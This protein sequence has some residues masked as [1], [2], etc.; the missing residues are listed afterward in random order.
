MVFWLKLLL[1]IWKIKFRLKVILI[2]H[3]FGC[4][5]IEI[6]VST[7]IFIIAVIL[8]IWSLIVIRIISLQILWLVFLWLV[9]F[10]CISSSITIS[11]IFLL[12]LILF[13]EIVHNIIFI[14]ITFFKN[15]LNHALSVSVLHWLFCCVVFYIPIWIIWTSITVVS[16]VLISSAR[17]STW[18]I[19]LA[20]YLMLFFKWN[21]VCIPSSV[22]RLSKCKWLWTSTPLFIW[23]GIVIISWVIWIFFLSFFLLSTQIRLETSVGLSFGFLS[24]F[25]KSV[26]S[27]TFILK[28]KWFTL[29]HGLIIILQSFCLISHYV[30]SKSL[31]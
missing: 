10:S 8:Q 23:L 24:C 26:S 16:N 7:F 22:R 14:S 20:I 2:L 11:L 19:L 18:S 13:I 4:H 28:I 25:S 30:F 9:N 1:F 21:S 27:Y 31:T 15:T 12:L 17:S 29:S 5:L 3:T 6:H